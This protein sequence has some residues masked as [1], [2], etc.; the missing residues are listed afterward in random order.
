MICSCN[1]GDK[2]IEGNIV[3]PAEDFEFVGLYYDDFERD[4]GILL[5]LAHDIEHALLGFDEGVQ[6]LELFV[7]QQGKIV[8]SVAGYTDDLLIR[9]GGSHLEALLVLLAV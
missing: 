9:E 1:R 5:H 4:G 6:L 7:V 8:F 2:E 3:L